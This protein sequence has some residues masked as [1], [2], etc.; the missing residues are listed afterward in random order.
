MSANHHTIYRFIV[1]AICLFISA[2]SMADRLLTLDSCLSLA[3]QHNKKIQQAALN[4]SKAEEVKKQAMTKYFPQVSAS[5]VGYHSL[6]PMVEIG[7]DD[8][9]NASV[10]DLLTTLYGNYGAALGLD[11]TLSLFH[12]GYQVG[13]TAVQPVYMGGK[14]VAGNQLANIGI[15]AAELQS[16]ITQR[17][18]LLEVEES[19]WLV[20]GLREKQTTLIAT[21]AL[22]DTIHQTVSAAVGAG[23]VLPKD[24]LQVELKQSEMRRMQIQ[25]TNGLQL[26][27]Q[28][29][30]LG[31]GIPYSDTL[32]IIPSTNSQIL[33][34][35]DKL[36]LDQP[37]PIT[38]EHQLLA[39]QVR[40]A[41]LQHRMALAEALPQ[42]AIGAHYGYGKLQTNILRNDLGSETGNGSVFVSVSV[43]LTGWW[44]TSHKMREQ[45]MALQHAQL[46]QE[47]MGEMLHMRT[48]QAYY[49]MQEADLMIQE[50]QNAVDITANHY[51]LTQ[52]SYQ[53][54]Q[55]TI[56]E[57][58]EAHTQLMQAQNSLTDAYIAYRVNARRYT[59]LNSA[60]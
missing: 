35:I 46:Q 1:L 19:Y 23:L 27:Q 33:P 17:D 7:I 22:L 25:L 11:N 55:A 49:Q 20:L 53:A 43:P 5:A 56:A 54:G 14:I 4:V 29:L 39:L 28:A 47:Q 52:A 21:M 38:T 42:I 16:Q 60:F 34:A 24:L 32:Q 58:L 13:V 40:S 2:H 41:Q 36:N 15:E 12:Y 50:H 59:T 30:C 51:R 26:A 37:S 44:E 45:K 10:R 6:H 9:S 57:L 8:I 48:K 31:I 3:Q 18:V